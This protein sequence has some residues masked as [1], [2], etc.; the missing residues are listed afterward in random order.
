MY[1]IRLQKEC[2][3]V[4]IEICSDQLYGKHDTKICTNEQQVW[5]YYIVKQY[6][7]I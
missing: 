5:I 3:A 1:L 2:L 7:I 4:F 6:N